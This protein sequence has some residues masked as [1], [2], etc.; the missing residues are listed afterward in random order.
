M[1]YICF[2]VKCIGMGEWLF[3]CGIGEFFE[4]LVEEKINNY[5]FFMVEEDCENCLFLDLSDNLII[6]V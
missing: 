1:D 5:L 6:C 4:L 3:N 2:S